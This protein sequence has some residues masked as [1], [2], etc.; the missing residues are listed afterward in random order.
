[1]SK[2]L[3]SRKMIVDDLE[4]ARLVSLED[5]VEAYTIFR[6]FL[7]DTT[8]AQ[9][10][11]PEEL[12]KRREQF[13]R[14][15]DRFTDENGQILNRFICGYSNS[16]V[17]ICLKKGEGWLSS[18]TMR[19]FSQYELGVHPEIEAIMIEIDFL[20]AESTRL[21]RGK[22]LNR[23]LGLIYKV[24]KNTLIL[25]DSLNQKGGTQSRYS[26][27]PATMDILGGDIPRVITRSRSADV[28]AEPVPDNLE[29]TIKVIEKNLQNARDYH[30]RAS[31]LTAQM[32][33][34]LGNTLGF[35]GILVIL[36]ILLLVNEV[37]L[38][39]TLEGTEADG[40]QTSNL[41]QVPLLLYFGITAGCI[42]AIIS[43]MN[44]ISTGN[45]KLNHEPDSKTI[46][47]IGLIR[48]LIGG[49]FGGL[50]L[51][52][53]NSGLS[54]F[55]MSSGKYEQVLSN[56]V[57]LGFIAGFFERFVPD[58]LDKT[59]GKLNDNG[60]SDAADDPAADQT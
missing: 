11:D 20:A 38:L 31:R 39:S 3:H 13:F 37:P 1:M 40:D 60:S 16:A 36:T 8:D 48:P 6:K 51:L 42:G 27:N 24:A 47:I 17:M 57:I 32:D 18:D 2:S 52:L 33:Y 56:L 22:S 30:N 4:G 34:F 14:I 45:L 28:D 58:L 44:R 50:L 5:Y 25:L 54:V 35:V 49:V 26:K 53:L 59:K 55:D 43:V 19:F 15:R 12:E 9:E 7:E 41:M 29:K 23:C 21:L 46:R 10:Q